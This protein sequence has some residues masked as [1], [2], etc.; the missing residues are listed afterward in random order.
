[1]KRRKMGSKGRIDD[2]IRLLIER[3]IGGAIPERYR[4]REVHPR[5][6]KKQEDAA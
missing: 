4:G 3:G 2:K 5:T 6:P 1:M